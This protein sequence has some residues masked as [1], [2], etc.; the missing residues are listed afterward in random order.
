MLSPSRTWYSDQVS[1]QPS[2]LTSWCSWLSVSSNKV[3]S[4]VAL[5][6]REPVTLFVD[7]DAVG[8]V[9]ER[10]SEPERKAAERHA[11]ELQAEP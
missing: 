7:L 9:G 4:G 5:F 8:G 10:R 1:V 3:R 2:R 6:G 11:R